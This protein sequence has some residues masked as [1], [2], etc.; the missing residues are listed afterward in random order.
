MNVNPPQAPDQS[1]RPR[2]II[3]GGGVAGLE[4]LLALRALAADRVT[5]MIVAPELRFV[6]RSM[7]A[8]QPFRPKRSRGLRL[9]DTVAE[10]GACWHRGRIDRVETWR[11][12]AV[13]TDGDE[14]YYD[15]LVLALGARPEREWTSAAVLTYHGGRDGPDYRAL[16]HQLVEGQI[17]KVAFV[18]PPGASWPL[19]LYDLALMTAARCAAAKRDD[20]ELSLITPEAEPL[21]I[22]G[23][24]A[25]AAT[26]ALLKNG[27]VALH[28]GSYGTPAGQERLTIMPGERSMQVDRVVTEPRLVGPRLRG[29][30]S[31]HD[32]FIRTDAFG[33][34]ANLDGV[35]AAG[36]ATMFPIKQ[37]GLAAQQ[38]DAVAELIAAFVGTEV[39]PQ[40]FRP[41]LRG[42]LLTGGAA[43]YLRADISGAAGD[44]ST[45]S[46]QALWWP[47]DK[48]CGRYLAPYLSSQVGEAAD[49]MPADEHALPVEARLKLEGAGTGGLDELRYLGLVSETR[50]TPA[51]ESGHVAIGGL[52]SPSALERSA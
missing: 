46:E 21:A 30:P 51:S 18:K 40:P 29:I 34:L 42:V 50:Q 52:D 5:V 28:T 10:L 2:V 49:V 31:E 35:F 1:C 8:D 44:D 13:T 20:V 43:R 36:D 3:A 37:G 4:T 27:G 11:K 14:L 25:S 12:R 26:R 9:Q 33:R 32:G 38:A 17:R 47:P 48:L 16:L 15:M 22:F 23:K 7:S 24:A 45:I 19:P 6:N 39:D 41:V